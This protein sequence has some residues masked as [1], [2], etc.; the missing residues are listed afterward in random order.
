[1]LFMF[2]LKNFS[3]I[4][5]YKNEVYILKGLIEF[6]DISDYDL[7]F[8]CGL[9][10]TFYLVWSLKLFVFWQNSLAHRAIKTE[11]GIAIILLSTFALSN[12]NTMV[13]LTY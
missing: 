8:F 5:F 1:M 12:T 6:Y 11:T 3:Q 13:N 7:I 9:I 10:Y 4:F 2:N